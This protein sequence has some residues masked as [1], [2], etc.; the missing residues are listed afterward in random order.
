MRNPT[1]QIKVVPEVLSSLL[2]G[3]PEHRPARAWSHRNGSKWSGLSVIR[4][5]CN[6]LQKLGLVLRYRSKIPLRQTLA[7]QAVQTNIGSAENLLPIISFLRAN[8]PQQEV[9]CGCCALLLRSNFSDA[10]RAR[11]GSSSGPGPHRSPQRDREGTR[12]GCHHRAQGDGADAR[13]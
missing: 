12:I 11:A 5:E 2:I 13:R 3:K 7:R 4:P 1:L 9:D 6:V 10:S 8:E